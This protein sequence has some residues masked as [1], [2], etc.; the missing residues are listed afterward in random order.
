MVH[1]DGS[2]SRS[3][4]WV[5]DDSNVFGATVVVHTNHHVVIH[6]FERILAHPKRSNTKGPQVSVVNEQRP[7]WMELRAKDE[8]PR[9]T[10]DGEA[11][12]G[13]RR[14][15]GRTVVALLHR[16]T[17]MEFLQWR[18]RGRWRG[19]W[20]GGDELAPT[21]EATTRLGFGRHQHW[22]PRRSLEEANDGSG[23]RPNVRTR[24]R[25]SCRGAAGGGKPARGPGAGSGDAALALRG[26]AGKGWRRRGEGDGIERMGIGRCGAGGR[27]RERWRSSGGLPAT[28]VI[29]LGAAGPRCKWAGLVAGLQGCWA[30]SLA[31]YSFH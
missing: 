27:T 10:E 31:L 22:W 29:E 26:D 20:H 8:Q 2:R 18:V 23:T 15:W 7:P 6:L 19:A 3:F 9:Q 28:R 25:R 17:T 24:Q 11:G 21:A 12:G 13:G 16:L 4:G 30:S 5:L 14:G 1:G